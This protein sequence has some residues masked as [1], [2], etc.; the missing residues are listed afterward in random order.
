MKCFKFRWQVKSPSILSKQ[1]V[2]ISG[3]FSCHN[4]Y[5][6]TRG[7]YCNQQI[8]PQAQGN[9]HSKSADKGILKNLITRLSVKPAVTFG[10]EIL[11]S[12]KPT[13]LGQRDRYRKSHQCLCDSWNEHI[14]SSVYRF[15][16]KARG[17]SSQHNG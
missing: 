15:C 12:L 8:H 9:E 11:R 1:E 6:A 2:Q 3:R 17:H 14:L 13:C 5:F 16:F 7:H 4:C 10:R